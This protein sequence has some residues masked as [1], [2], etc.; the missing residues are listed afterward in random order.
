MSLTIDELQLEI[1]AESSDAEKTLDA[2]ASTLGRIKSTVKGGIGLTTTVNQLKNL[3]SVVS[4]LQAPG[5]KIGQLV[6]SLQ[7]LQEI[8]KS[9]LGSALNQLKKVPQVI[10][11]LDS[12][13]LSRFGSQ[14]NALVT[15]I[16]PLSTEMEKVSRGFSL[17]PTNIQKAINA[18]AKLTAS[19]NKTRKSYT[20][21]G[22]GISSVTAKFGIY[23]AT[24]R[25][26]YDI[27]GGWV[28]KS[29]EYVENLN[30][31]T[32]S[33]GPYAEEAL[34]YAE[35]VQD[36]MGI[37][38]SEWIRNQGVFMQIA[39]G[40]GVMEDK[41]YTM[42]RGLTQ[43]AYDMSSYFNE[44]IS[45][46]LEKVQAGIS[47]ELEPLRR[48]GY[49][50]DAATLQQVAYSHGITL[51]I[52]AMTQAQKSQLR[53]V[54]IMEQSQNVM[55]DMA[56]TLITP[57]NATRILSQQ[58]TQLTR[59]LGNMFIPILIK[60]I[61]YV[62][63]FVIVLTEAAQAVANFLGFELPSIDYSG[64]D[65]LASGAE[66]AASGLG[67]AVSTAKELQRTI[68]GIDEINKLNDNTT[69]G[70]GSGAGGGSYDLGLD[71]S[72]WDY[73]F[74]GDI[75]SEANRIADNIRSFFKEWGGL[76]KDIAVLMG[77]IWAISKIKKFFLW[78]KNIWDLLKATKVVKTAA[79]LFDVFSTT[80]WNS[81][82]NGESFFKS[83]KTGLRN[84][85]KNMSTFQK[86]A[87]SAVALSAEFA[88]MK[89]NAYDLTMGNKDLDDALLQLIPTFTIVGT[90]MYAMWGPAG[91]VVAAATGLV[92]VIA[93]V[94]EANK[95]LGEEAYKATDTYQEMAFI[96][97]DS[98]EMIEQSQSGLDSLQ[99]KLDGLNNV[100]VEWL[101]IQNLVD[102]IYQL[103]DKSDK[104]AYEIELLGTKVELLNSYNLDGLQLTYDKTTGKI[105][106][107]RDSIQQ[108]IDKMKEQAQTAA[109][110]EILTEAYKQQASASINVVKA[111][112]EMKEAIDAH[113]EAQE[114]L[115]AFEDEYYESTGNHL[116]L[117][118]DVFIPKY[119]ELKAAV[120]HTSEAVEISTQAFNDNKALLEE[121]ET[122][123]RNAE[124][125]MV[126]LKE[127][128]DNA[129]A[130][131]DD[132]T[133]VVK[134]AHDIIDQESRSWWDEFKENFFNTQQWKK[135]AKD[136]SVEMQNN[137]KAPKLNDISLNVLYNP[138]KTKDD[139]TTL[140]ALGLKGFPFLQWTLRAGGGFPSVG[141]MFIAKESGPEMV[142]RI[143][144]KT[145]VANEQQ[146]TTALQNAVA[147]GLSQGGGYGSGGNWTIQIVDT[148]GHVKAETIITEAERK[149]RRDGRTVIPVG[150]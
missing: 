132:Y 33:M 62:Q 117:F 13:D 131:T 120:D 76:I 114:N 70:S 106:E 29:N 121:A 100:D 45:T 105:I 80:L 21:L 73:D 147:R 14:I 32:V 40:F 86:A 81:A 9:N 54:A 82:L 142:G 128:I 27:I 58:I 53:Y 84:I 116:G 39:T 143:G 18:N 88:V 83:F 11:S 90:A 59:A 66:D 115:K 85:G 60:I 63:A 96:I 118:D 64:M 149:N 7:P 123:I 44:D 2:L 8:E 145:A 35:T 72:A 48:W 139:K 61:P 51:S 127:G 25:R 113:K 97:E 26:I 140:E 50:L 56:R 77:T 34:A 41:A 22:T 102:E 141:E 135:A 137:L 126:E 133:G 78:L 93:G 67:D 43:I 91:V 24:A 138:A 99:S 107:T 3:N 12:A 17:L 122:Q 74:L 136:A 55:G 134:D 109:Y 103:S 75:E 37:D 71:L 36:K 69:A 119:A 129:S 94:A 148:D 101:S 144:R 150:V 28:D 104:S 65:G 47:G 108:V 49:A 87:V 23:A 5:Q 16:K 1:S 124:D 38:M 20:F 92:G 79:S 31:F 19:N 10:E 46:A 98:N 68:L 42:S 6:K 95:T 57:A 111:H 146:I 52:N 15:Y 30:L 4:N 110:Q 112:D 125:A 89:G 130:S